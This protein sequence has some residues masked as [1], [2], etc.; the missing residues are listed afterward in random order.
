MTQPHPV[1]VRRTGSARRRGPCGDHTDRPADTATGAAHA[2]FGGAARTPGLD[3]TP[4]ASFAAV[5]AS[6]AALDARD[7]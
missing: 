5:T 2:A 4:A 7:Q 6:P 1:R 3:A